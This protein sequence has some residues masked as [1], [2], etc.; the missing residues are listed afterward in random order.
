MSYKGGCRNGSRAV[1]TGKIRDIFLALVPHRDTRLLVRKYSEEL[2]RSGLTGVYTFPWVAPLAVLSRPLCDEELKKIAHYLRETIGRE[3]INAL[4]I[5]TTKFSAVTEDMTLL[6]PRLDLVITDNEPGKITKKIKSFLS[7][8]VIG[9]YLLPTCYPELNITIPPCEKLEFRAAAV[10]NMFW[11]PFKTAD[12][13]G[14]KWKIGKLFWLPN[15]KS[16][17]NK[18]QTLLKDNYK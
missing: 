16:T 15:E 10:A 9:T 18:Q 5:S 11:R 3:K 2:Y 12:Q 17:Y 4:E 7:P 8:M 1:N 6:G 14:Y 13:K